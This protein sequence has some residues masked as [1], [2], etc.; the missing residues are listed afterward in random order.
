MNRPPLS[1]VT[2]SM[3][4][5]PRD[6]CSNSKRANISWPTEFPRS[7]VIRWNRS[8]PRYERSASCISA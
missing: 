7:W 2:E 6:C 5:R 3:G 1:Q 8:M 4:T